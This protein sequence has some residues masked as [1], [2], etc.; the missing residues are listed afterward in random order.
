MKTLG[1][2][3]RALREAVGITQKDLAEE[4]G[5]ALKT[6]QRYENEQSRPDFYALS[7]LATFFDVSSDYLLGICG[8]K[9]ECDISNM[10]DG[11]PHYKQYLKCRN[12]YCIDENTVY[13]WINA[14]GDK[15]GGQTHFIGWVDEPGGQERRV[16]TE[17]NPEMAIKLCSDIYRRPMVLNCKEDIKAFLIYGG[18]AIVKKDVCEKYLPWYLKEFIV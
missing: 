16:L 1:E 17:I 18:D 10:R 9:A 14:T 4:L 15:I 6:L 11:N 5:I 13:Y 8:Y 12:N 2:K 3:I 7:R